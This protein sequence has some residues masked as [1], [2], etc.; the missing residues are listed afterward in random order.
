MKKLFIILGLGMLLASCAT[1]H[2]G[3]DAVG[4]KVVVVRDNDGKIIKQIH[5]CEN[6]KVVVVYNR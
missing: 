3:V 4:N 2:R 1:T 5:K 6:K